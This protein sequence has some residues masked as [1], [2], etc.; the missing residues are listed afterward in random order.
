MKTHTSLV[1]KIIN[2][3]V[4]GQGLGLSVHVH[5]G[6][7]I[8]LSWNP[9]AKTGYQNCT[10]RHTV[11]SS[12]WYEIIRQVRHRCLTGMCK[13]VY[14]TVTGFEK[15]TIDE[16]CFYTTYSGIRY[17]CWCK[18][19]F[20]LEIGENYRSLIF[21]TESCMMLFEATYGALGEC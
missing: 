12:V 13:C 18:S 2:R 8:H 16:V 7:T 5:T 19:E 9:G 4:A 3:S 20:S 15:E 11:Q 21:L 14:G 10:A 6:L 1:Q 17:Y